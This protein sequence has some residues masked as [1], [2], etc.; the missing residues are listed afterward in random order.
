MIWYSAQ[1]QTATHLRIPL[2]IICILIVPS[3][4]ERSTGFSPSPRV[5]NA[6]F[7]K[8]DKLEI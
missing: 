1:Q 7:G 8:A 6:G 5:A 3:L 4:S 2:L